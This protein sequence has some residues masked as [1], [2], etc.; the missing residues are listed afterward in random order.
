VWKKKG[1]SL[2]TRASSPSSGHAGFLNINPT[3]GQHDSQKTFLQM[4]HCHA[5]GFRIP[6]ISFPHLAQKPLITFI[7]LA[8]V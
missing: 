6:P 1:N 5:F 3:F 7:P 2:Y 8:K 4:G